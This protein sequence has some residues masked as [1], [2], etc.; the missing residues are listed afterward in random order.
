MECSW[1]T[2]ILWALIHLLLI[3]QVAFVL[4]LLAAMQIFVNRSAMLFFFLY[5]CLES[6]FAGNGFRLNLLISSLR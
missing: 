1:V 3:S 4:G 2:F 6:S 5:T